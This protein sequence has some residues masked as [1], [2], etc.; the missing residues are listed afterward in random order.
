MNKKELVIVLVITFLVVIIWVISDIIHQRSQI[1]I[2][3]ELQEASEPLD[4]AFDVSTLETISQTQ[5]TSS[6]ANA[7]P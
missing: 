5:S 2:K 3:P 6:S 7:S 4:P 1:T